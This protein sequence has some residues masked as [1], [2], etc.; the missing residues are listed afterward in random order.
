MGT[1]SRCKASQGAHLLTPMHWKRTG[2]RDLPVGGGWGARC[3]WLDTQAATKWLTVQE[4]NRN[5]G[6]RLQRRDLRGQR[7]LEDMFIYRNG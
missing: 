5:A 4:R 3:S 1:E 6:R 7:V 2:S